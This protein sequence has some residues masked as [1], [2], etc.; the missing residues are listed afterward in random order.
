MTKQRISDPAL[1]A[2]ARRLLDETA[3]RRAELAERRD[4]DTE[5]PGDG[6]SRERDQ[7]TPP[8]QS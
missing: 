4:T 3:D 8:E 1:L 7:V 2:E 5:V 6:D